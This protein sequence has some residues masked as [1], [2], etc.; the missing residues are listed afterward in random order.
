MIF[1]K[2]KLPTK[3]DIYFGVYVGVVSRCEFDFINDMWIVRCTALCVRTRMK[4]TSMFFFQ[5]T[6]TR[7]WWQAAGLLSVLD[8]DTYQQGLVVDRVFAMCHNEDE[9]LWVELQRFSGAYGITEMM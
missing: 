1:G 9:Q 8:N 3:L 5:C 6:T 4:M 2:L 7:K